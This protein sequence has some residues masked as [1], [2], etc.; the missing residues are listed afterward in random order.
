MV[1][2]EPT[3]AQRAFERPPNTNGGTVHP[4]A[5]LCESCGGPAQVTALQGYANGKPVR[6]QFCL[7]CADR[8]LDLHEG[9]TAPPPRRRLSPAALLL[10]GG[11]VL[12]LVGL[13][14]GDF[15]DP[16]RRGFGAYQLAAVL[17]GTLLVTVGAMLRADV[18]AVAGTILFGLGVLADLFVAV[19]ATGV[20]WRQAAAMV[21]G[22]TSM[23]AGLA[24]R[25]LRPGQARRDTPAPRNE[26]ESSPCNP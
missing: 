22:L 24:L 17:A 19:G 9:R 8:A 4:V 2:I 3:D 16:A 12:V 18:V 6:R 14:A 11:L 25:H 5:R 21:V 7:R 10:L 20:G 23:G 26:T 1:T 15:G 13:L